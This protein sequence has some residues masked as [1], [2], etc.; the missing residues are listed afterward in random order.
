[1]DVKLFEKLAERDGRGVD[2]NCLAKET[3]T[4]VALISMSES[5]ITLHLY[6]VLSFRY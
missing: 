3:G 1:M 6:Q 2:A 4:D 5:N